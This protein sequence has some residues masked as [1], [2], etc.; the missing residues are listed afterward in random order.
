WRSRSRIQITQ[1][2]MAASASQKIRLRI[3]SSTW[4]NNGTYAVVGF[5]EAGCPL[6]V[7]PKSPFVVG[8]QR[9]SRCRPTTRM[10]LGGTKSLQNPG[11]ADCVSPIN[12]EHRE[13]NVVI[14]P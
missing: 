12:K 2:M 4:L 9:R 13:G 11:K 14:I 7:S 6:G 10:S 8:L 5:G 3:I 1:P